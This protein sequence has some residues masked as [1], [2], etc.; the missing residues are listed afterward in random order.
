MHDAPVRLNSSEVHE[1]LGGI[2]AID[3]LI[4]VSMDENEPKIILFA[5]GLRMFFTKPCAATRPL[6]EAARA[7]GHLARVAG[8][9]AADM[10]DFEVVRALE[11]LQGD[12]HGH[13]QQTQRRHSACLVLRELA[14][15]APAAFFMHM[16]TFFERIWTGLGDAV[17]A[18]R[19]AAC[20]ALCQCLKLGERR[21]ARD[22][23][24][25]CI[26]TFEAVR[27]FGAAAS[28]V[29]GSLLAVRALLGHS[30][31][32]AAFR[33]RVCQGPVQ[34]LAAQAGAACRVGAAATARSVLPRGVHRRP[35]QAMR[36]PAQGGR[37]VFAR[38]RVRRHR[39]DG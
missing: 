30:G 15:N 3:R 1:K 34:G 22:M 27:G 12:G 9:G 13:P 23:Q 7:L 19:E 17:A 20:E 33:R 31:D 11:W 8:P 2:A 37:V 10:V 35:A 26:R 25:Y 14:L 6:A 18:I 4:D 24:R 32:F 36:G 28:A 38:H 5:N 21:R 16:S 39:R 29:H